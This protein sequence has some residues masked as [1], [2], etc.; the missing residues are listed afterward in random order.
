MGSACS[1]ED[2]LRHRENMKN[3][4]NPTESYDTWQQ[5]MLLDI[6]ADPLAVIRDFPRMMVYVGTETHHNYLPDGC[7]NTDDSGKPITVAAGLSR[8][9]SGNPFAPSS[10]A[11]HKTESGGSGNE[12]NNTASHTHRRHRHHRRNSSSHAR[13][14][15]ADQGR[16]PLWEDATGAD[17]DI[18]NNNNATPGLSLRVSPLPPQRLYS[19]SR[20][21]PREQPCDE[22][23]FAARVKR[24]REEVLLLSEL[25]DERA[26]FGAAFETAWDRLVAHGNNDGAAESESASESLAAPQSQQQQQQQDGQLPASVIAKRNA[27][28][29]LPLDVHQVL[30]NA[31]VAS[32]MIALSDEH[33]HAVPP[34]KALHTASVSLSPQVGPGA[35]P[36]LPPTHTSGV[37]RNS[38]SELV[39]ATA[40]QLP[41]ATAAA[42]LLSEEV[43]TDGGDGNTAK[44]GV[45][46]TLRH[47]LE[48]EKMA[49]S[50]SNSQT[51]S[52]ASLVAPGTPAV[53]LG[54]A[55]RYVVRSATFHLMQFATQCVMF[56]P[57]QRLKH[58]LWVPWSTQMQDVSWTIHFSLKEAT[59]TDLIALRQHTLNE[60]YNNASTVLSNEVNA[61]GAAELGNPSLPD[62]T[63]AVL[64]ANNNKRSSNADQ[65]ADV[66]GVAAITA[67][68]PDADIRAPATIGSAP[69]RNSHANKNNELAE[70]KG[71][72]KII[73]I[74][75]LQT[76]RS[77]VEDGDRKK[78]PR[79]ELDWACRISLDQET[80]QDTFARFQKLAA[81]SSSA[82]TVPQ[83]SDAAISIPHSLVRRAMKSEEEIGNAAAENSL[84]VN[85]AAPRE[86]SG[87][88]MLDT[89]CAASALGTEGIPSTQQ[90]T[91][92]QREVISATVEVVAARVERPPH[93]LCVVSSTWKRRKEELDYLL[94]QQYNVHLEE[95]RGLRS[96]R[97]S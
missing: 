34:L 31:C 22:D 61:V 26:T 75:H 88:D 4:N 19:G 38:P 95:R 3:R 53:P 86:E 48:R 40:F 16:P 35:L 92:L 36:P 67:A 91:L 41:E 20:A 21:S 7:R 43:P 79:Y 62:T 8:G 65:T 72:R 15:K 12:G 71:G 55:S 29:A 49:K 47:A 56:F 58:V 54:N 6:G 28:N 76:C 64:A 2:A 82:K 25:C 18:N 74:Q 5:K 13:K 32:G 80:L 66:F 1:T 9:Q 59:A 44:K 10:G 23:I 50:S 93:T 37:G 45:K 17:H 39:S 30:L 69:A 97:V 33:G 42:Q 24:V 63:S 70:H 94:E 14:N 84:T 60:L 81:T 78:I 77:Y 27:H 51:R 83:L 57:V 90:P 87:M 11:Q 52:G 68:L 73:M 89:E 85:Q 46:D 96:K